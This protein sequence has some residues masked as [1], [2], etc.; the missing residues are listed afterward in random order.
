MN[1][2]IQLIEKNSGEVLFSC[3]VD[4]ADKAYDFAKDLES[5]G[6]EF[7]FIKPGVPETLINELQISDDQKE[8]YAASLDQ[9]IHDHDDSCCHD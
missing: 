9:E 8:E 6:V 3:P 2:K 5:M 4:Q 1:S 7:D